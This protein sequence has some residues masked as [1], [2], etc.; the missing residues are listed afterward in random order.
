MSEAADEARRARL[1]I[2]NGYASLHG[3]AAFAKNDLVAS[4][5]RPKRHNR[6]IERGAL[7]S[8]LILDT[9]CRRSIADGTVVP[10]P[11]LA[12][13]QTRYEVYAGVQT[14]HAVLPFT[15]AER[16][17]LLPTYTGIAPLFREDESTVP[18]AGL[19]ERW[20]EWLWMDEFERPQN[21]IEALGA[22]AILLESCTRL[23]ASLLE[24]M[25]N[26]WN[27]IDP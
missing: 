3:N 27:A 20:H 8:A 9:D 21:S 19:L 4:M 23:C 13:V 25:N 2:Y 1:D 18:D 6:G 24:V 5:K 17:V 11:N 10:A 14:V 22:S 16:D 26:S 12:S 7:A 15:L